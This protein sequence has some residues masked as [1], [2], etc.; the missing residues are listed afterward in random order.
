MKS[1]DTFLVSVAGKTCGFGI[2]PIYGQYCVTKL[3]NSNSPFGNNFMLLTFGGM[4]LLALMVPLISLDL[5]DNMIVQFISL[6]YLVILL[7]TW[8]IQG[9]SVGLNLTL[10][11]AVGSDWSVVIGNVLF[12][13]SKKI[14]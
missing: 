11:P 9:F 5:N 10:M 6:V 1:F 7:L 3:L 2:S 8:I 4:I 13:F 12:N 14:H